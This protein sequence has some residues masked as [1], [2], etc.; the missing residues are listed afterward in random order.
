MK[1]SELMDILGEMDPELEVWI[2]AI[3]ELYGCGF[4][5]MTKHDVAVR[6]GRVEIS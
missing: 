1:I 2:Y 3:D 4:E 5:R 6:N